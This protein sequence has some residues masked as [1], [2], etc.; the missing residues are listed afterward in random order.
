MGLNTEIIEKQLAVF[1]NAQ[2]K[3]RSALPVYL[4]I[5]EFLAQYMDSADGRAAGRFPAEPDMAKAFHVSRETIRAALARLE[6]EHK[7]CRVKK[8]GTVF[9]SQML[10]FDS[11][12]PRQNIGVVWPEGSNA[13]W[14]NMLRI[15]QDAAKNG[16]YSVQFYFYCMGNETAM[17]RQA[18]R[19]LAECFGTVFYPS[20]YRADPSFLESLPE[21]A[22]LV[23]F[24]VPPQNSCFSSVIPD[25]QF[26]GYVFTRELLARGCSNPGIVRVREDIFSSVQLENGYREAL[27]N[28][29]I[30]FRKENVFHVRRGYSNN[31]FLEWLDGNGIDALVLVCP[32][33]PNCFTLFHPQVLETIRSHRILIASNSPLDDY[34]ET[35]QAIIPCHAEYPYQEFSNELL[36]LLVLKMKNPDITSSQIMIRPK[37]CK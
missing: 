13:K 14:R 3:R 16:G 19:S 15:F 5:A 20:I 8:R 34:G 25:H 2:I 31:A 1:R 24:D 28:A 17:N 21:T 35:A 9:A 6:E 37:I 36:R 11:Q 22:P 27:R 23:L 26:A 30:P 29:G 32:I 18:E 12:S 4:Q 10:P 7:I 33:L